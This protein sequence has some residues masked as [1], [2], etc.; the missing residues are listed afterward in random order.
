MENLTL[1][2]S[3]ATLYTWGENAHLA[4]VP[5]ESPLDVLH[6]RH[7]TESHLFFHLLFNCLKLIS[8]FLH[9]HT[10]TLLSV[11]VQNYC[12]RYRQTSYTHHV[13]AHNSMCNIHSP[14][15]VFWLWSVVPTK[16]Q[17]CIP[18]MY[19]HFVRNGA[20]RPFMQ[21]LFMY[22][23]LLLRVFS[24]RGT[25]LLGENRKDDVTLQH[26]VVTIKKLRSLHHHPLF[27]NKFWPFWRIPW[28]RSCLKMSGACL[29]QLDPSHRTV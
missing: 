12:L 21:V 29:Q 2:K 14:A 8:S 25:L 17:G 7:V 13:P 5:V 1:G 16:W 9:T 23:T 27:S 20:M 6:C 15:N 4:L 19:P 28:L 26:T 24:F 18:A 3:S 10:H 11:H 22:I